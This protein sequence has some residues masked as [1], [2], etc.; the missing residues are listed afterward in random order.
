MN[1][2]NASVLNAMRGALYGQSASLT[3]YK[4]TPVE[5]EVEIYT[6]RNGWHAQRD[7]S[8]VENKLRIWMSSEVNSI[9]LDR[10]LHAGAKVVMEANGRRQS[11]RIEMINPMQQIGTGWMIVCLPADNSTEPDNG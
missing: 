6:T 7:N 4:V 2:I 3:F 9:N 10:S 1:L 11:W 8:K 5:G